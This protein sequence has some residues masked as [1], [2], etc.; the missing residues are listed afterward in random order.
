MWTST[1]TLWE[2]LMFSS[3][4]WK[5]FDFSTTEYFNA[6]LGGESNALRKSLDKIS[7]E[8]KES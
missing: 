8:V 5:R 7:E 4:F 3:G 1:L 6:A 2:R